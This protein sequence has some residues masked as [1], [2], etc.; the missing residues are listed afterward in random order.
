MANSSP[1]RPRTARVSPAPAWR[2]SVAYPMSDPPDISD[3]L[4]ESRNSPEAHRRNFAEAQREHD[5]VLKAAL[6]V[7]DLHQ[8]A[9]AQREI[10]EEE[11]RRRQRV[12]EEAKRIEKERQ[13]KIKQL[14][15]EARLAAQKAAPIPKPVI[16]APP[17]PPPPAAVTAAT[18]AAAAQVSPSPIPSLPPPATAQ[19]PAKKQEQPQPSV[20][21]QPPSQT[22]ANPFAQ[23]QR[24]LLNGTAAS[25]PFGVVSPKPPATQSP[26]PSPVTNG[27]STAAVTAPAKAAPIQ[28]AASAAAP[29]AAP[30]KHDRYIEVHKNL[31]QLRK[32]VVEQAKTNPALKS[33]MGDM[34][35][36]IRKSFGQLTSGGL[37]ENKIPV[38]RIIT[39][40]TAGLKEVPSE[41]MDP[42]QFV[43]EPR[44]QPVEGGVHNEPQLPS[45]YL[46]L[47]NILSKAA[48]SQFIQESGADPRTAEAIG[49]TVSKVY[50]EAEFLWRGKP[51]IDMLIAKY[52]VVCPV[53]F[54]FRGNDK[55]QRGR[56]QVGWRKEGGQWIGE[57]DHI[58]R[59]TGLGAG[60]AAIT[61][62]DFS[63]AKR[64]SPWPPAVYWTAL[65]QIVNTPPEEMSETQCYV[66][67]AMIADNESK[68]L[69]FY[70]NAGVA[71]LRC[72]LVDYP[73]R[74]PK[75]SAASETLKVLAKTINVKTGLDLEGI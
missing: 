11:K 21:Q 20:A 27:T 63:R 53:L 36:D 24:S 34:R 64:D 25:S 68:F 54:G 42:N 33:R 7:F 28:T 22:L 51:M 50:S 4:L 14:E 73:A 2:H 74:F 55:M 12:A 35:R 70:G 18:A 65:A 1:P 29:A 8:L 71:A 17:A 13:A 60:F 59:M 44:T 38:A 56:A 49:Q 66:L 43:L 39:T 26:S 45:L 16:A 67:K 10:E 47:L 31:K 62:R 37:R 41:M 3:F 23:S 30:T 69:G 15:D 5:R 32:F 72:A 75:A 40:L 61:L 48:I 58:D 6:H 9:E 57:Q 52:R 46:Y 19:E